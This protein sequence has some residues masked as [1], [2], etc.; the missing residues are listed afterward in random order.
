MYHISSYI[1]ERFRSDKT[2]IH[3]FSLEKLLWLSMLWTRRPQATFPDTYD[4]T[5]ERQRWVTQTGLSDTQ[6]TTPFPSLTSFCPSY[7][8]L[9]GWQD[10]SHRN[11]NTSSLYVQHAVRHQK[12]LEIPRFL[13]DTLIAVGAPAV[14]LKHIDELMASYL[15]K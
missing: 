1:L 4:E 2:P 14:D 12:S 9:L 8:T 7:L 5:D 15:R 11:G 3:I 10:L 6:T 13:W